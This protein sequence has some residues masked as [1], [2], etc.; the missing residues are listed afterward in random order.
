MGNTAGE[1]RAPQR[2]LLVEDDNDAREA[3]ARV[4]KQAGHQ[5]STASSIE[6]ALAV[7]TSDAFFDV[8]ITDVVL[9]Q[10]GPDGIELVSMLREKGVRAPVIAVTAFADTPRLKRA[11][12]SGV[13]YLIEKPF[14][15]KA[16]LE[17]LERFS[18]E[19]YDLSHLVSRALS[20]ACLT[21]KEIEVA[22]LLLKGLSNEEIAQATN[23]S[24]KTIR[25][26]VTAL[27]RKIGVSSRAEFFHFVFPT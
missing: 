10:D 6:Q 13:A 24:D 1:S 4:L 23:N 9:S 7:A 5:C 27:Y 17:I 8:V 15:A 19:P 2:I 22:R 20:R 14:R 12:N 26:H 16:L 11:L 25:Q 21:E 3:L 18:G